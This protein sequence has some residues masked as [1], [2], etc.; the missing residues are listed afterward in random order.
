[1]VV[2]GITLIGVSAIMNEA[3]STSGSSGS[4][5]FGV[6]LIVLSLVLQAGIFISEEVIMKKYHFE[7][8]YVV[9][10]EGAFLI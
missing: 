9:G 10:T 7:P 4:E 3:P 8:P 1:M 5:S 2:T 6:L